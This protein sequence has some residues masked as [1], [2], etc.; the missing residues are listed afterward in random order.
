MKILQLIDTLS[1]GG[2]ERMA[3]NIS[4]ELINHGH[5][6]WLCAS[7]EGGAL[8]SFVNKKVNYCQLRKKNGLDIV[9]IFRLIKLIKNNKITL[10]HAH[11]SS[12]F[13]SVT[14]KMI[15]P[16]L[17]IVWHDHNGARGKVRLKNELYIFLS[18]LIN[19][20]ISVNDELCKWAVRNLKVNKG[21]IIQLNN[22]PY[23]E[24]V[25]NRGNNNSTFK[26]VCIANLRPVKDQLTLIKAISKLRNLLPDLSFKLFLA[27]SYYN[28]EYF[29]KI[30]ALIENFD[31]ESI[32]EIAGPVDNVSELL[33]KSDL[34]VLS[35]ISEGLPVSLL[36]Y[37]L[38]GLPVVVTDVGQCAEVVD[39][40][41][42]GLVVPPSNPEA[43]AEALLDL[44]EHPEKRKLYGNRLK[45]RVQKEYGAGKFLEE[46]EKLIERL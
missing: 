22:F 1:A 3:V 32:I 38:A 17:K 26:I 30:K 40:G 41:N 9:A 44:I 14:V 12:I 10:I 21:N 23:L 27:G 36:E 46:Y 4:N 13:W 42:A 29:Y 15:C 28:D 5:D 18:P 37:G 6:V 33:G 8:E 11:S 20:V 7:R 45:E 19:G 43:L 39:F 24:P 25:K 16:G 2:A 34:G 31:L 35:S